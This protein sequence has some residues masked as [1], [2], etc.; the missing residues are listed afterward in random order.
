MLDKKISTLLNAQINKELFSAYVYLDISNYF[1][2]EGLEGFGNWY[3]I[4]AKE[5]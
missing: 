5:E 4:Q 2:D 3:K 1:Y